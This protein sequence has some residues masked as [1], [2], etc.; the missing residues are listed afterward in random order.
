MSQALGL[1]PIVLF[2]FSKRKETGFFYLLAYMLY[3]FLTDNALNAIIFNVSK[4]QYLGLRIFTI[5]EY[6]LLTILFIKNIRSKNIKK[7]ITLISILFT[8]FAFFDIFQSKSIS[9]DSFPSG[10]ESIL[11]ILYS[12]YY[13]FEK[14]N[15][16]DS[17]YLYNTPMFWVVVGLILYFSGTFF[18]YIYGQ[19]N[20][21]DAAFRSTYQLVNAGFNALKLIFFSVAFLVKPPKESF[22]LLK[23]KATPG[24]AH[25]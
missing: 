22:P 25:L 3:S 19:N 7:L 2:F 21:A 1:V 11:I 6:L 9:F 16:P 24:S 18:L 10:I 5:I 14:I 23:P 17:I 20:M 15:E 12:I 8:A 4:Q 13:L